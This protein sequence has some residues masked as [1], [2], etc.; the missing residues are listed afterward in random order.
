[1]A[2]VPAPVQHAGLIE[3][4]VISGDLRSLTAEQRVS[5]YAKVCDSL[6]LNPYTKPFEYITLNGK[7]TLYAKCDCTDQLRRKHAV[8]ITITD[9]QRI[10]DVY[11]VTAKATLPDGRC[12][13]S[14]GAVNIQGLKGDALANALMKAET[15]GKRRVTLSIVG[16]GWLDESEVEGISDATPHTVEQAHDPKQ[17]LSAPEKPKPAP[18]TGRRPMAGKQMPV[19]GRE[20]K[21][22][23]EDYEAKLV[24]QGLCQPGEL[25]THVSD[26]GEHADLDADM[27]QWDAAGIRLGV[28]A[29]RAF[30]EARERQRQEPQ[31]PFAGGR[32][33]D[34]VNDLF[35]QLGYTDEDVAEYLSHFDGCRTVAGLTQEQTGIVLRDLR[36]KVARASQ[37]Q[38]V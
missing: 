13:E 33:M 6:G 31:R 2:N 11:V 1:M 34:E 23:L 36:D 8:S 27:E 19:T 15:K 4:V 10:E 5:Y 32:Q 35:R 18:A 12:D 28:D 9:R 17:A 26:M 7:L 22:R 25:V 30:G 14:V 3:Q 21:Q 38:P 29:A 16:L 24:K 37:A 20:L